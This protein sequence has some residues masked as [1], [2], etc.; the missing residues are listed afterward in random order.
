VCLGPR[1]TSLLRAGGPPALRDPQT[2]WK[3]KNIISGHAAGAA[4]EP[5]G[6]AALWAAACLQRSAGGPAPDARLTAAYLAL[7]D[8]LAR[9]AAGEQPDPKGAAGGCNPQGR[10]CLAASPLERVGGARSARR[11]CAG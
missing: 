1:T 8:A 7:M 3:R 10:G 11:A 9:A 4:A 5:L 6:A 2:P